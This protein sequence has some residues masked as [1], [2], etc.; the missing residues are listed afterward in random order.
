LASAAVRVA[1]LAARLYKSLKGFTT[2]LPCTPCPL[3]EHTTLN[4][5][6]TYGG[7]K[8]QLALCAA[9]PKSLTTG[10][11]SKSRRPAQ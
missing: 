4:Y 5:A 9:L 6:T 7:T 2:C 11:M 10:Q 8:L 1:A 3:A